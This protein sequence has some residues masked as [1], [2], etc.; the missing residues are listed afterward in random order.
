[1]G[2]FRRIIYRTV[3]IYTT[4]DSFSRVVSHPVVFTLLMFRVWYNVSKIIPHVSFLST[5]R[6][7]FQ[8]QN[9]RTKAPLHMYHLVSYIVV[10]IST[11]PIDCMIMPLLGGFKLLLLRQNKS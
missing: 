11:F 2:H 3:I 10:A 7:T 4:I 9:P 5:F 8:S 1:M 6:N